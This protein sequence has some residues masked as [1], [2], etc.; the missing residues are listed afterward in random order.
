[1]GYDE[2][3]SIHRAF[4]RRCPTDVDL[5]AWFGIHANGRHEPHW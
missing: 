5:H 2:N 1:M 3:S 4:G